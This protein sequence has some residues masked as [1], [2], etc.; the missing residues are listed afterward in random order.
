L[1]EILAL[2][3]SIHRPLNDLALISNHHGTLSL[4]ELAEVIVRSFLKEP[5]ERQN[6]QAHLCSH[7]ENGERDFE[8]KIIAQL[9]DVSTDPGVPE[10]Y[11]D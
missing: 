10:R 6:S 4:L 3:G 7:M 2:S 9:L 1:W 5:L 11:A 8:Q